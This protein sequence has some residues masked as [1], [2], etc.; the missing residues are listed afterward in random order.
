MTECKTFLIALFLSRYSFNPCPTPYLQS[1]CCLTVSKVAVR[2]TPVNY[3]TCDV[4]YK[5]FLLVY[6][7]VN[8]LVAIGPNPND[9][10]K[11]L[12]TVEENRNAIS[13][14]NQTTLENARS[15]IITII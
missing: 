1:L 6:I 14:Q 12:F 2:K 8:T 9:L 11:L 3:Q 13:S 10:V 5:P 4:I 15:K 7:E